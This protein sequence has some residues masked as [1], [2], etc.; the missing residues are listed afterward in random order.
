MNGALERVFTRLGVEQSMTKRLRWSFMI[1]LTL[2]VIPVMISVYLMASYSMGYHSIIV[3]MEQISE[4]KPVVTESI[5][6]DLFS[7][8]AGRNGFA[9]SH[10]WDKI[11]SVNQRLDAL[12]GSGN[13]EMIVA[14]R[15][16]NTLANYVTAMEELISAEAPVA[17]SEALLEEVRSVA[18]L[19][20][21]MLD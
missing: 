17:Q 8:V 3:R 19:V 16:M 9:G 15:T 21:A 14:R 13:T 7:I 18:T 2:L 12:E 20:G 10:V 1:I 5:P 11:R 6:D 4:L